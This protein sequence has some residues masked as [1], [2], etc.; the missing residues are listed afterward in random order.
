MAASRRQFS[1]AAGA[2]VAATAFA[3]EITGKNN[4]LNYRL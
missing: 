3:Q 4:V 2:A 1:R